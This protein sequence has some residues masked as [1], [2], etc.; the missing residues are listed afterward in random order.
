ME[1]VTWY[2]GIVTSSNIS[3]TTKQYAL[4]SLTKLSTRFSSV[5]AEIQRIIETF[6]SHLDAD[7]QQRGVEFGQLFRSQA[8]MRSQL[9]EPMPVLERDKTLGGQTS[10]PSLAVRENGEPSVQP[11]SQASSGLMDLLGLDDGSSSSLL[12]AGPSPTGAAPST[13]LD[14]ILGL[15]LGE[16]TGTSLGVPSLLDITASTP[17]SS[18]TSNATNGGLDSLLNGLDSVNYTAAPAQLEVPTVTAYEKHGL[19]VVFTFPSPSATTTNIL[20]LA[21]N[22]TSSPIQDFIFQVRAK[23][24]SVASVGIPFAGRSAQD[25]EDQPGASIL[26]HHPGRGPGHTAAPGPQQQQ[27]SAQDE[28]QAQ[29]CSWR[30]SCQR[31]GRS[32]K[33]SLCSIQLVLRLF[34]FQ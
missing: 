23:L 13:A 5:T 10:G 9:L 20:L 30:H 32:F 14:D 2:Q 16:N 6:G 17:S 26:P 21:N 11:E 15:S 29:L 27:S 25:N 7:L 22:L 4:M 19:K 1:V 18:N 31:S 3:V 28:A 34:R 24:V 8:G 33:F 12:A